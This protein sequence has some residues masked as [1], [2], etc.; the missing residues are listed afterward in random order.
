[1]YDDNLS[2]LESVDSGLI[3]TNCTRTTL[4]RAENITIT[5]NL[6]K[7][8]NETLTNFGLT[9]CYRP[10]L[11]MFDFLP[12]FITLDDMVDDHY[13]STMSAVYDQLPAKLNETQLNVC[14]RDG[15]QQ[16]EL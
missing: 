6:D 11:N 5:V 15:T 16:K 1:M 12:A 4:K 14:K 7:W 13:Y 3:L 9:E 8:R 10:S 2:G